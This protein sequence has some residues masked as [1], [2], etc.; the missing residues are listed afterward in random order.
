MIYELS[1]G[2]KRTNFTSIEKIYQV[3]HKNN[4]FLDLSK[5]NPNYQ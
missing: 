5:K 3:I 1:T 2:K 4:Y